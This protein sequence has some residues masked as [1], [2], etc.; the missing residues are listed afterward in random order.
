[1]RIG[2]SPWGSSRE[3]AVAAADV[4][5]AA[6]VDTLWLGDGLLTVPDFPQWAGGME[7]FVELAWLAGRY[8]AVRVGLGAA[9]L[10]L[11]DVVWLVKQA[12]TLDQLTAGRF[13][14][15]VAP[16]YWRREFEYLGLDFDRRGERFDDLLLALQAGFVGA[17]YD[18]D[19]LRWPGDGRLSP[20]PFTAGGPPFWL[21]GGRA[22]FERALRT[23]RP[24][25]ARGPAHPRELAP[26]AAEWHDRGGA[27]LALRVSFEVAETVDESHPTETVIGPP[28]YLAEQVLAYAEQGVADLSVRPGQSDEASRRAVDALGEEIIPALRSWR[29]GR[30]GFTGQKET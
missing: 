27:D 22:T 24:F 29:A 28:S 3:G 6:G 19:E 2:V 26:L 23:G 11:R 15:V 17:P 12:S 13:D 10:P 14:L 30:S 16:G 20:E 18:G 5:V 25:Q 4:A 8:P 21:A 1:V 9:V 7:P